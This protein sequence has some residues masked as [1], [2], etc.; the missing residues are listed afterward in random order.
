MRAFGVLRVRWQVLIPK[1]AVLLCLCVILYAEEI[2]PTF[3]LHTTSVVTDFVIDG[4][5]LYAATD[6]GVVDIFDLNSK[7]IIEQ[8]LLEPIRTSRGEMA[9]ARIH[10]VDRHNGKT[11]IVSDSNGS[12]FRSVWIYEAG[13][14]RHVI[15]SEQQLLIKKAR[16]INDEQ[17]LLGTF[18][19]EIVLYDYAER[20]TRYKRHLS[21]STLGDMMLDKEHRKMVMADESGTVRIIDVA[22]GA[23]E[24]VL[25]SENVDNIYRVAYR[26]GVVVTA[27]QDRRLGVYVPNEEAYHIQSDFLIYCAA[28]SP[29]GN[30][31]VYSSGTESDLQL[32][33]IQTK[34]M[35]S[36][37]VGH[38]ALINTLL[39][40]NEHEL[41]SAGDER[42][43]FYWQ[44]P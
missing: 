36:R 44:L 23:V 18:A 37:L 25:D 20:S 15:G 35:G 5:R 3:Q 6:A 11:L 33:N 21:H 9:P 13:S 2:R 26:N 41:F 16:F 17:L 28:L 8:I 32:F 29:S 40:L 27:G 43:I 4:T 39:F 10:S 7:Q 12:V 1:L 42:Y 24:R 19:S 22:S 34:V 14:L 30:T 31:A 38:R